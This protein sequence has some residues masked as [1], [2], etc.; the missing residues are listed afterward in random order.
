MARS[1]ISRR[2]FPSGTALTI[3]AGHAPLAELRAA[4]AQNVPFI[5]TSG[6]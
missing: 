6:S 4:A 5:T 3:A 1:K 2:D